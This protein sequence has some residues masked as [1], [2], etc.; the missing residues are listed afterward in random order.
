MKKCPVFL[1]FILILIISFQL[2][3]QIQGG[4]SPAN[5]SADSLALPSS[6]KANDDAAVRAAVLRDMQQEHA[7]NNQEIKRQLNKFETRI[8]QL[9]STLVNERNSNRRVENLVERVQ[10]LEKKENAVNTNVLNVFQHNYKSAVINLMFM[11]RELKPLEL[12]QST[13]D[14]FS[15]LFNV[16]NPTSYPGFQQWYNQYKDFVERNKSRDAK[17]EVVSTVLDLTGNLSEKIPLAGPLAGMLL[18]GVSSFMASFKGRDPM[19][20]TSLGMLRTLSILSQFSHDVLTIENEWEAINKE[21]ASLQVLQNNI[22]QENFKLLDIK[23]ADFERAFTRQTDA[24]RRF[25]YIR[26]LSRTIAERV[27]IERENNPEKWKTVFHHQMQ[28]VQSLKIRFGTLTFRIRENIEQYRKLIQR[29]TKVQDPEIARRMT[30]LAG[31]LERLDRTFD[32]TFSPQQ[33]IE[34]AN[35]MYIV[36]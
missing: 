22:L 23:P 2:Q 11:E 36:D 31:K 30:D 29:Y 6:G 15:T 27:R 8:A 13:K 1:S 10:V 12:F 33:Y 16:A 18:D 14:F 25:D 28:A 5:P 20:E 35:Q 7:Q 24:N 34:A 32:A 17:L 9:D 21:L 4:L 26:D 3:A 19:R